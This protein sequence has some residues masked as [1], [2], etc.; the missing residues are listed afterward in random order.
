MKV[1]KRDGRAVEYNKEKIKIAIGKANKEVAKEEKASTRQIDNIIKYIEQLN[2]KRI[3]V[4]DIQ[5]IIE[6]KLMEQKKYELAKK[7]IIYRYKRALVRKQNTTDESI[8]GLLKG[9]TNR[10]YIKAN[11]LSE[12]RTLIAKEVSKDIS[13]RILIKE[14]IVKAHKNGEIYFHNM[15]YFIDSAIDTSLINLDD[16]LRNGFEINGVKQK[17]PI[18][19]FD[20][21]GKTIEIVKDVISNQYGTLTIDIKPLSKYLEKTKEKQDKELFKEE[22]STGVKIL[23]LSLNNIENNDAILYLNIE[24]TKYEES[25]NLLIKEILEEK[26]KNTYSNVKL[27]YVLNEINKK[28]REYEYLTDLAI[29]C[30]Q[31]TNYPN[32]LSEKMMKEKYKC[33]FPPIG[34][35]IFLPPVKV[36]G[37]VIN[38]GR[39]SQGLVSIN[40]AHIALENKYDIDKFY[41]GLEE[42]LEIA[43]EALICKYFAIRGTTTTG[44]PTHFENGAIARLEKGENIDKLLRRNYSCISLGYIGLTD[45]VKYLSKEKDINTL[46][47]L[48][49]DILKFIKER[50]NLWNEQYNIS[51]VLT[52]PDEK[53]VNKYFYEKD[54]ELL[55]RVDKDGYDKNA[56]FIKDLKDINKEKEFH[57]ISDGYISKIKLPDDLEEAKDM[58]NLIYENIMYVGKRN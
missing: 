58:L 7:Y 2:K 20:A 51:F 17:E 45:A 12:K 27:I 54:K 25:L 3:L 48:A 14:N 13:E 55:P 16:M 1:I 6:K 33:L 5:D 32:F 56:D 4:E 57:Q 49:T 21:I 52:S 50:C 28:D 42:K 9:T 34:I 26:I 23:L 46:H 29:E 36:D 11:K 24:K 37:K 43:K 19:F 41:K 22:L 35:Q 31:K 8:L 10:E 53:N 30:H 38:Q 15:D 47:K 39:F 44:S 40:L 18:N